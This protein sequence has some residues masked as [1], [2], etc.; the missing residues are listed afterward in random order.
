MI[1]HPAPFP[2]GESETSNHDRYAIVEMVESDQGLGRQI[3]S[4]PLVV[5]AIFQLERNGALFGVEGHR[6]PRWA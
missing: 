1:G 6:V 2:R 3:T 4:E 5:T